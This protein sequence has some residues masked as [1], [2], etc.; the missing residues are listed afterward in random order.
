M[1]R[2]ETQVGTLR[3][4][5]VRKGGRYWCQRQ[6]NLMQVH[7]RGSFVRRPAMVFSLF[8]WLSLQCDLVRSRPS[9][10]GI[11]STQVIVVELKP[12]LHSSVV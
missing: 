2:K 12:N 7:I 8:L 10:W 11:L 3:R 6:D 4:M 1:R 9:V 5:A